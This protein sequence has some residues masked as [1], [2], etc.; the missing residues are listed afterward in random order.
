M[1]WIFSHAI[2][3]VMRTP[4]LDPDIAL[5][6]VGYKGTFHMQAYA[7]SPAEVIEVLFGY[8]ILKLSPKK[9]SVRFK[10]LKYIRF[11]VI[12]AIIIFILLGFSLSYWHYMPIDANNYLTAHALI[13]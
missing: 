2:L 10:S 3:E 9:T 8:I 4:K 11:T 1:T 12:V 6:K 7:K 5:V 13:H